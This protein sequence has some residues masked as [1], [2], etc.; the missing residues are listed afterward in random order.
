VSTRRRQTRRLVGLLVV[1]IVVGLSG[2]DTQAEP[3]RN[4]SSE[5]VGD[6]DIAL[7][8]S[9]NPPKTAEPAALTLVVSKAGEAAALSPDDLELMVDMPG[10]PM[11]VPEVG[12]EMI[13]DGRYE[14]RVEFPMA[15]DWVATVRVAG[16]QQSAT[17]AFEVNP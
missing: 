16:E 5:Q 17:F 13:D 7:E 14:A 8:L 1:G 11:N 12:L 10:M 9:P 6:Y 3:F 15:G 2:C 4:G